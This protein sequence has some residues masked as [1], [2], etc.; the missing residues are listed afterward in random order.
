MNHSHQGVLLSNLTGGSGYTVV[1]A[2][3]EPKQK[4]GHPTRKTVRGQSLSLSNREP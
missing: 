1:M 3:G 2:T 4:A